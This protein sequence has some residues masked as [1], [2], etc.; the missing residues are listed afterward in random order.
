MTVDTGEAGHQRGAVIRLEFREFATIDDA[1][2]DVVHVVGNSRVDRHDVV[3]LGLVGGRVDGRRDVPQV[4]LPRAQSRHDPPYD[5]QRVAVVV[6]QV[7][8][9]AG[10]LGVQV[11]AAEFLGGD[12]FSG[13]RLHQ[14]RTAEEDRAL[15]ADDHR[16]VAH[17]GHVR[18]AGRA[19]T[20]HRGD[21]RNAFGAH[22][23][24]VV[25][26][27]AEVLAIRETPRPA[28]A[29]TRRPSRR[30]RCTAACSAARPPGRAGA[31]SP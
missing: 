17:R 26:D 5:P 1:C 6:R 4:G 15:V 12:H 3:K 9:D 8:G 7:V 14:R 25:E 20:E 13:R 27:P 19:R 23:R 11:A 10:G 28:W 31:F 24:L 16:L 29:G 18:A 30:G 22:R 21:L 2:D